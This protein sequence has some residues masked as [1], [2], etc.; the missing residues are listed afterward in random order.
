LIGGAGEH[1]YHVLQKCSAPFILFCTELQHWGNGIF[2]MALSK[3]AKSELQRVSRRIYFFNVIRSSHYSNMTAV[4]YD[5]FTI[6]V[7]PSGSA[8]FGRWNR[9][10]LSAAE[11]APMR[12]TSK[13]HYYTLTA[14][15]VGTLSAPHGEKGP[16][17]WMAEVKHIS[18]TNTK[19]VFQEVRWNPREFP[20]N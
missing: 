9:K 16:I 6:P 1:Q 17:V 20:R 4:G 14:P 7:R 19:I 13:N 11:G 15:F 18:K 2:A 12:I 8:T 3:P 5:N 10:W